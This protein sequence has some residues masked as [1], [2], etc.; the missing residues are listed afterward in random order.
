MKTE[1]PSTPA[2]KLPIGFFS[3][4]ASAILGA[5]ASNALPAA[6]IFNIDRRFTPPVFIW[7]LSSIR[8]TPF[9]KSNGL[10]LDI[11]LRRF[12]YREGTDYVRSEE[13]TSELQ[14]LMR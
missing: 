1:S 3:S 13:H 5:P 14:S 9:S 4:A 6:P 12:E 2:G 7:F 8:K 11:G 10:M